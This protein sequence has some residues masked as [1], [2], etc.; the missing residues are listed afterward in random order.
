MRRDLDIVFRA[1]ASAEIGTGHVMRCLTLA[2]EL[3]RR[4][5]RVGFVCR[6][7]CGHLGDEVLRRG[8]TLTLLP[9]L[10]SHTESG[11]LGVPVDVDAEETRAALRAGGRLAWLVT[12]GYG[13]D[14]E[15]ESSLRDA[16]DA[17]MAIDDLADRAHD[18]DLL[19]DQNL[20]IDVGAR[21]A[22]LVPADCRQL[23][24][25]WFALLRP[26]FAEQQRRERDGVVRRILVS[27]GGRDQLDLT[28][29]ALRALAQV[30][31]PGVAVDVVL[32][33]AAPHFAVVSAFAAGLPGVEVH[34]AVDDMAAMMD[35]ADLLLGGGG[36]MTWERCLLGLPALTVTAAPNQVESAAA[37]EAAGATRYLG[38]AE[39][40]SEVGLADAVRE[41]LAA[42]ETLVAMS[43]AARRLVP[44]A[45]GTKRVA[46]AMLSSGSCG[47]YR[48]RPMRE[49]DLALVL[50]WRNSE[51]VRP[52]MRSRHEISADEHAAWFAREDGCPDA[53]HM[54]FEC[55]GGPLGVVNFDEVDRGAGTCEWGFYIGADDAPRGS[56]VRM[57]WLA[58]EYAFD[59]LAVEKVSAEVLPTN[60]RSL[61]YHEKLGFVETPPAEGLRRFVLEER[62]WRQRRAAIADAYFEKGSR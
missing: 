62:S 35:A 51:R 40:V 32:P 6:E 56:G 59:R 41:A 13:I 60:A 22:T 34:R 55:A 57:G 53:R 28:S 19:L 18:C 10:A 11:W 38:P 30:V 33:A 23:L 39:H 17:I 36:S 5:E 48:L 43:R 8:H 37:V 24:G 12:D 26:Q 21:Y 9:P 7:L 44:D 49:A 27:F 58:L 29:R 45:L 61:D 2:D 42:P 14:A 3:A 20:A 16:A 50:G 1:D 4:G 46:R 52:F 15:W 31:Q 25:P 47:G 54:V